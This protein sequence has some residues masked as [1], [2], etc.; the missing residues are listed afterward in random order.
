LEALVEETRREGG[1]AWLL[2]SVSCDPVETSTNQDLFSRAEEYSRWLAEVQSG[3]QSLA[4]LSRQEVLRLHRQLRR[5][6]E[7]LRAIDFFPGEESRQAEGAWR[8]FTSE[9][10]A[11]MSPDEPQP[12]SGAVRKLD[13]LLYQ[14]R[15]WATRQEIWVDRVASAWLIRRFI[16]ARATFVWLASVEDCPP[17]ALGFDFDGASFTHVGDLVTFE[18]LIASFSL[19]QDAALG[20]IATMVH[21]LDAEG[22]PTAEARGFEFILNGARHRL[23]NDDQILQEIGTALDSLYS[24]FQHEQMPEEV[25]R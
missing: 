7:T 21:S 22:E 2:R 15:C 8:E 11:V 9:I 3:R 18:V 1:T 20:R 4:V 14:G 17:D 24:H 19:S 23:Q 25:A 5:S 10:N 16:D 12:T 13:P 6:F